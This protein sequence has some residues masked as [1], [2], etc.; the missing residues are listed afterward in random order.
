MPKVQEINISAQEQVSCFS[1]HFKL[2]KKEVLGNVKI[3]S[4]RFRKE[5]IT[6][7]NQLKQRGK[8]DRNKIELKSPKQIHNSGQLQQVKRRSTLLTG[9]T[10]HHPKKVNIATFTTLKLGTNG[11][12]FPYIKL[13][14]QA[15]LQSKLIKQVR[16]INI[17]A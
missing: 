14:H 8:T 7:Y 9:I 1:H 12:S 10:S 17:H 2:G 15:N 11:A 13:H 3:L 6:N 4:R 5:T 16:Y